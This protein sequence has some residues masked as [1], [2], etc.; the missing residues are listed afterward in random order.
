LRNLLPSRERIFKSL[1]TSRETSGLH[2]G[3][4]VPWVSRT[5]RGSEK[6]LNSFQIIGTFFLQEK[7]VFGLHEKLQDYTEVWGTMVFWGNVENSGFITNL[8]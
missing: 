5:F 7:E 2:G 4:V 3:T 1:R 6:V 8:G